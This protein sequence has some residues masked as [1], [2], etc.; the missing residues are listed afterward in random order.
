MVIEDWSK[1]GLKLVRYI[2]DGDCQTVMGDLIF[3]E[4]T[5]DSNSS[6]LYFLR[7]RYLYFFYIFKNP[8]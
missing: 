1:A 8:K 6:P 4:R 2:T 5:K 7:N 3:N